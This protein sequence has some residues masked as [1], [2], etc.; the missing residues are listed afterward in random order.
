MGTR[1][2]KA[3]AWPVGLL[4]A[5]CVVVLLQVLAQAGLAGG[6][7]TGEVALLDL[8]SINGNALFGTSAVLVAAAVLVV[9]PGHGPW[10]PI[11][12]SA[13]LWL[14]MTAQ[15]VLGYARMV[16]LHIPVGVAL[17]GLVSGLTWWG[18]AYRAGR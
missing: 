10:W 6:F 2:G 12:V 14:L 1:A 3:P 17:M 18:F 9:R 11:V 5:V 13:A 16:G 4:R 7:V 8:H 15:A